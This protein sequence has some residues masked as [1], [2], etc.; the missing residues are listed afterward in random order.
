MSI[1]KIEFKIATN[2]FTGGKNSPMSPQEYSTTNDKLKT[3]TG[4]EIMKYL[5]VDFVN[6]DI[7]KG[8]SGFEKSYVPDFGYKETIEFGEKSIKSGWKMMFD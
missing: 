5:N 3:K 7:A 2:N 6:S 8:I 1:P 4:Q